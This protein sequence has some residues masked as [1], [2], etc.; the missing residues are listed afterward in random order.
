MQFYVQVDM[1]I[2]DTE[3][4]NKICG[5]CRGNGLHRWHM[6]RDCNM[7]SDDADNPNIKSTRKKV[8]ETCRFISKAWFGTPARTAS[9]SWS[10]IKSVSLSWVPA[11]RLVALDDECWLFFCLLLMEPATFLMMLTSSFL[12][13]QLWLDCQA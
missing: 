12:W 5:F 6:R 10:P 3:Q 2:V 7:T 1:I 9:K 8:K 13:C 11:A 4:H